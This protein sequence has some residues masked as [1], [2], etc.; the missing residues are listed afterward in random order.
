MPFA[1]SVAAADMIELVGGEEAAT[2]VAA[3]ATIVVLGGLAGER[4]AFAIA[5]HLFAGM[6]TGYLALLA[7]REVLVPRLLEP[8][9]AGEADRLELWILLAIA[10]VT[11]AAPWLPRIVAAI[12]I[13]LLIGSLAAF[14]LGG[15]LVGTALPQAAATIVDTGSPAS[16]A[17]G[18]VALVI[19]VLV[20]VALLHARPSGGAAR[21]AVSAGRWLLVAGLG[22]WLGFLL[23]SRLALLVDRVAFLIVDWLGMGR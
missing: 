10:A 8:L 15:A 19:T 4:R 2:W 22:A 6:L 17:G 16:V 11:A 14:A 18:L 12:P 13:S 3:L 9:L 21:G 20:L 1:P 5:Q 7:I 23:V